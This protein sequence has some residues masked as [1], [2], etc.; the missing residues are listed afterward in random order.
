M[1]IAGDF[2]YAIRVLR[3]TPALTVPAV[4]SLALGIAVNT[5]IFSVVNALLLRP[6]GESGT[7]VRLGR[8][9]NDDGSFR[10]ISYAEFDFLQQHARSFDDVVGSEIGSVFLAG[11][12]ESEF[13]SAEVVTSNYFR[14]LKKL[15]SIGRGFDEHAIDEPGVIISDRLWRRRFA[16]DPALIGRNVS[17]N[18]QSFT[19][20]G[21]ARSGFS[22]TFP[23]VATDLWLP[24]IR[25]DAARDNDPR[26]LE[27]MDVIGILNTRTSLATA[28]AELQVLTRRMAELNPQRDRARGLVLAEARGIHPALARRIGPFALAMMGIVSVVLLIACANVASLL[29]ARAAARRMELGLRLALGASRRRVVAQLLIESLLLAL[30]GGMVGVVLSFWAVGTINALTLT[31]G[32]TGA[33]VFLDLRLDRRVLGFT[34]AATLFTTIAFGLLPAVQGTRVNLISAL[35]DPQS[36][37]DRR[38]SRLRGAL[39]IVQVTTSVVLLVGAVLLFRSVRNSARMDLGFDPD[40]VTVVSFNLQTLGYDRLRTEQFYA[41]LLRRAR[42]MPDVDRAAL[43]D[44]VPMAGRGGTVTVLN[45]RSTLPS[46]DERLS[47]AYNRVSDDYFATVG[48]PLI[49]G[50]GFTSQDRPGAPPV[51]IVNEALSRQFWPNDDA[52]GKR[53]R[54][55]TE[56]GDRGTEREIVGIAK[57]A[58]YGSFGGDVGPFVFL[59]ALEQLGRAG[60]LHVRAFSNTSAVL[61]PINRL[62]REMDERVVPR[63]SRTMRDAMSFAL[64]PTQIAQTVFGVAGA[65]ALLLATG[66]LYGLV[67][68]TLQQ[69]FKEIGLRVA[70]GASPEQIFRLIVGGTVRL[71]AIGV[72]AG[73]LL[74]AFAMRLLAWMLIGLSP[75][76]PLTFAG[77]AALMLIVTLGAGYVGA[78]QG[79][80][81]DPAAVLKYE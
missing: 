80:S 50:R 71:T 12:Q 68:Y 15:P 41:E 19:I 23:G 73:V 30:M 51:A 27:S 20:I 42:E 67:C 62:V 38:R 4:A 54:I 31:A 40:R 79:L 53:L 64:I 5:T 81:V 49:R 44:F 57:D 1:S 26:A 37:P 36:S 45:P 43:A 6:L 48:Q 34:A 39:L 10:S 66:G 22:G 46:G 13:V 77:V 65:T 17:I 35:K 24:S 47:V 32:P 29:L 11:S 78:R 8:S 9:M 7:I 72:A 33:P 63:T 3:S 76:D 52:I 25:A 70:L 55:V 61:A 60:T 58:R 18:N 21:I 16:A 56:P 75:I 69:R 14:V 74:A 28:R 2:R 59:P